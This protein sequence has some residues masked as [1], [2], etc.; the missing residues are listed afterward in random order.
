MIIEF[1]IVFHGQERLPT[2][3]I[4]SI[5]SGVLILMQ[6]ISTCFIVILEGVSNKFW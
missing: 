1:A 6:V 2:K 5:Q 3:K 4:L